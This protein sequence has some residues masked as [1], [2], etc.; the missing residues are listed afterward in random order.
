M[1]ILV[2]EALLIP[3]GLSMEGKEI[4]TLLML[5]LLCW[6]RPVGDALLA[7]PG[8]LC[9]PNSNRNAAYSQQIVRSFFAF[10]SGA[11]VHGQEQVCFLVSPSEGAYL[12]DS[13]ELD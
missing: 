11:R 13:F 6:R 3:Y 4:Y 7:G 9:L 5:A 8:R 10:G 1:H 2:V 12:P